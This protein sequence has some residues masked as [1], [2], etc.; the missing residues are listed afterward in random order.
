MNR[1]WSISFLI[2]VFSFSNAASAAVV[3]KT[4]EVTSTDFF[5]VNGNGAEAPTDPLSIVFSVTFDNAADIESSTNGLNIISA[6]VPYSAEYSYDSNS[7][8]LV[9]ATNSGVGSCLL[10]ASSFCIFMSSFSTAPVSIGALQATSVAGIWRSD[11][12]TISAVPEPAA[13]AFMIFGFGAIGGAM[14]R[15]HKTNMKIS[16]A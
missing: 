9:L 4:L 8:L 5:F 12:T 1:F 15:Y 13:W 7:D 14:R 10:P 11:N 6:S 3:M 2:T 16:Y